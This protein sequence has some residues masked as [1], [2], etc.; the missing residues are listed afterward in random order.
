MFFEALL[1][2]AYIFMP[3]LVARWIPWVGKISW[4]RKWQPTPV[5]LPGESHGWSS[6]V[7]YSPW[8]G[9]ELDTTEQIRSLS[10]LASRSYPILCDL[11]D[12]SP[13]GS[14]VHGDFPGKNTG[15][16]CY[17]LL[18][19]IFPDP[20]PDQIKPRSPR[21]QADSLLSEPPGKHIYL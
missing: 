19:G 14:S 16:D 15:V 12:C 10:L 7:G 8:G 18:Q 5:F 11:M 4:R 2:E 6:L 13:P 3:C 21:L 17:A 1:F 9:K 20:G